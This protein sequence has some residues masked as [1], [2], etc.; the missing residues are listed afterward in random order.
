M[1]LIDADKLHIPS[2]EMIS[3]MVIANAPTVNA[4]PM[5]VIED[6]KAEIQTELD[7]ETYGHDIITEQGIR[8]GYLGTL[9]IIDKH[10]GGENNVK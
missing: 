4:I 9:S 10:I 7:R 5:S 8:T 1:R 2:E 3:A 6:I